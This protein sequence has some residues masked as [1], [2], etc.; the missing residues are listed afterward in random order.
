MWVLWPCHPP[1]GTE[2][3]DLPSPARLSLRQLHP[4]LRFAK[5]LTDTKLLAARNRKF[6]EEL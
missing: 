4:S 3:E 2:S 5:G 6:I 1:W